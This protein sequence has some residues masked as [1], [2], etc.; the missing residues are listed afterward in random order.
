MGVLLGDE[1]NF[2]LF[3]DA[4]DRKQPVPTLDEC[5]QLSGL[6]AATRRVGELSR[7]VSLSPRLISFR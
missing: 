5:S 6:R 3:G 7:L 4:G 2:Y 1:L